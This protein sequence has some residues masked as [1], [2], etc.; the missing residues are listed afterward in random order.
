MLQI[1]FTSL[2]LFICSLVS[3]KS[4]IMFPE[5]PKQSIAN[6]CINLLFESPLGATTCHHQS[7]NPQILTYVCLCNLFLENKNSKK[8]FHIFFFKP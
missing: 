2:C 6:D 8:R 7:N 1:C 3:G 5:P 4:S